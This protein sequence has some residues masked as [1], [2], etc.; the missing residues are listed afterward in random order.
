M[1]KLNKTSKHLPV[2]PLA[3][4]RR[5]RQNFT[6]RSLVQESHLRVTDLIMPFFV[7]HGTR[8]R[9]PISSM[10]GQFQLSID[11]L[12]R[13]LKNVESLG[14]RAILLFGLPD[15]KDPLG[16]QAY[17]IN[18]I[19]QKAIRA[20]KKHFPQLIVMAD[21]CFCEYTD[22]GHCGVL[23]PSKQGVDVDNDK[24]LKL[25][26][27]AALAQAEAGVDFV[28]PS[29]MMDGA[30]KTIRQALDRK[31]YFR[32]GILSYSAKY[33]SAFYGP[34]REAAQSAPQFGD[35]R[36]YQM[37]PPNSKEALREILTDITEGADMVMVKP[38]LSYLD[39]LFQVRSHVHVPV[40]AYNVSGEYAMVK[41]AEK[42]GWLEGGQNCRSAMEILTSMKRAGADLIITY[43][44]LEVAR[45]LHERNR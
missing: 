36:S 40:V 5:L 38:A 1:P 14:I 9:H 21:L 30:V 19:V 31:K 26:E 27:K 25:I 10:P 37:D 44:A 43:H 13:E 33:A 23:T 7:V 45:Q 3:R 16:R 22:H 29:G 8:L 11:E 41:A 2:F 24:T 4:G 6:V 20:V 35:R 32:V 42:M 17:A 18:G 39:I 12:L 34:F 28:A 15:K